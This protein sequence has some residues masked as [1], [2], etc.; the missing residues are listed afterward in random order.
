M[1]ATRVDKPDAAA[2]AVN[3]P[4]SSRF[5]DTLL[6]KMRRCFFV[7]IIDGQTSS[8]SLSAPSWPAPSTSLRA[9]LSPSLSPS[10][11]LSLVIHMP[12]VP[13]HAMPCIY[14]PNIR[15]SSCAGALLHSQK[16]QSRRRQAGPPPVSVHQAANKPPVLAWP[17]LAQR[18]RLQSVPPLAAPY[19]S[20]T[21]TTNYSFTIHPS[22]SNRFTD[23]PVQ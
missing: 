2:K 1:N 17:R 15:A 14:L 18:R 16:Q 4:V 5:V 12:H 21:T 10:P 6:L 23:G 22:S 8:D 20:S 13:C 3:R 7:V 11:C 19:R 9:T